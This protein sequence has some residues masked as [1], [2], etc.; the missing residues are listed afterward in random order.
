MASCNTAP[1]HAWTHSPKWWS[2]GHMMLSNLT[3]TKRPGLS[4][5]CN[6]PPKKHFSSCPELLNC[7]WHHNTTPI[8]CQESCRL[9]SSLLLDGDMNSLPPSFNNAGRRSPQGS[10][11]L[12]GKR[13]SIRGTSL[14]SRSRCRV[15]RVKGPSL[16]RHGGP[17]LPNHKFGQST[18]PGNLIRHEDF[19]ECIRDFMSNSA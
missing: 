7:V 11:I 15:L 1:A 8:F 14:R 10:C 6:S 4:L 3:V 12:N 17:P 9:F 18:L 19:R 2:R 16:T 5:M 13:F